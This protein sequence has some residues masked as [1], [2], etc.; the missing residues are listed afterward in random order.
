[1]LKTPHPGVC[2]YSQDAMEGLGFLNYSG[3]MPYK[4]TLQD[5]KSLYVRLFEGF[6]RIANWW[7]WVKGRTHD[8]YIG[9]Q[10][11]Y[12]NQ[13]LWVDDLKSTQKN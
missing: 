12:T 9:R 11:L 2:L 8:T 1:M 3:C 7:N 6:Y 10:V 4:A 13:T 5:H